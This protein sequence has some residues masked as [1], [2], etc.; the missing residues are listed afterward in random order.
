MSAKAG[1]CCALV[2][3]LLGI[4]AVHGEDPPAQPNGSDLSGV[5]GAPRGDTLP[6][7]TTPPAPHGDAV[8]SAGE[9]GPHGLS[10]WITYHCDDCCGPVGGNG[11]IN[12]ELFLRTGPNFPVGRTYFD[13]NMET[14]WEVEG[15]GRSLFF[16]PALDAA[17]T[18]SLS[19][20]H[21]YN[22][23]RNPDTTVK[24][25]P[26]GSEDPSKLFPVT[27]RTLQRTFGSLGL[28]REWYLMPPVECSAVKWRVGA[29]FGPRLGT[30]KVDFAEIRHRTDTIYGIYGSIHTD[31][32]Y[33]GCGC[34]TFLAGLR[35]EYEYTNS[36]S[37]LQGVTQGSMQDLNLLM[38]FGVRF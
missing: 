36:D 7:G 25:F 1:F 32:E 22:H 24:L 15:G 9:E 11:P 26:T 5:P 38:E 16:N 3:S 13:H 2:L 12:Y 14:G 28:G 31:V 37:I 18:V 29:D 23:N 27:V 33:S 20:S 21:T 6:S 19:L 35:F 10:S 34:C 4:C 30:S 17:W 8:P